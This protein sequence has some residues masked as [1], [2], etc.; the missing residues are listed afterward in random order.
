MNL[1]NDKFYPCTVRHASF[2]SA[3]CPNY[4]S[5]YFVYVWRLDPSDG[6]ALPCVAL[7][8]L[9]FLR[10]LLIGFGI[11]SITIRLRK[12]IDFFL[13]EFTAR[14]HH[15]ANAAHPHMKGTAIVTTWTSFCGGL[16]PYLLWLNALWHLST[17]RFKNLLYSPVGSIAPCQN[18]YQISISRKC[19]LA[20]FATRK[21]EN[22]NLYY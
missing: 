21:V 22:L 2:V 18:H 5:Q 1:L 19:K 9:L 17:V 4:L 13:R 14:R 7:R 6:N 11:L 8:V 15:F 10:F 12:S 16:F 3:L 20:F